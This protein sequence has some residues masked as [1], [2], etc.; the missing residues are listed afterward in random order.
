MEAVASGFEGVRMGD[1]L[2]PDGFPPGWQV[3]AYREVAL[4]PRR[5]RYAVCVFVINE[6]DRLRA[7]LRAMRPLAD[8]ADVII[9]DGGSTDGSTEPGYLAGEG[10]ATLLVKTGPG[11]L[12]AQMRM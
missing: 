1:G 4:R 7:Q 12:G 8:L 2:T 3:P 6:G 9:A 5:T 11:K 10:V